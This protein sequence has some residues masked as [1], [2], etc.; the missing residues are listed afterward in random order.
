MNSR[1]PMQL[2]LPQE[3]KEWIKAESDRN[4]NSQN[5][6][7]IRAIRAAKDRRSTLGS[8]GKINMD[9]GDNARC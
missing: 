1:K 4:G 2:R 3:L 6:E 8:V 7:V 9:Q 5:S